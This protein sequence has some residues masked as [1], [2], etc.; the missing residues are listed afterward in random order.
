MTTPKHAEQYRS[1]LLEDTLP[2]WVEHA[3]DEE[4]GG[5]LTSLDRAGAVHDSDKWI[6]LQGRFSWLLATVAAGLPEHVEAPRWRRLARHGVEFLLRHGFNPDG[7]M[8]FQVTREGLHLRTRR[9]P[10]SEAFTA[11]AFARCGALDGDLGL[12][13]RAVELFAGLE[14]RSQRFAPKSDQE[15]R[16]TRGLALPMI[17]LHVG[18]ELAAC[19][20]AERFEEAGVDLEGELESA[21]AAIRGQWSEEHGVLLETSAPEGG[22]AAGFEGRTL[23][24][25]HAIEATWFLLHEAE[26]R[27]EVGHTGAEELRE[28]ALRALDASWERGWDREYGGLLYF[29][30]LEGKPPT[31]YLHDMKFWWPHN[32]AVIATLYAARSAP[33]DPRWKRRHEEVHDWA[34]AHFPDAEHGEWFGYLARDGRVTSE[35]KGTAWKGP[36]HLPRMQWIG[37]RLAAEATR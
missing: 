17:R 22:P 29:V 37:W 10:F 26:R 8:R 24:P 5:F 31:E 11:L 23:N 36:Y 30:D 7:T 25:G 15:T 12:E 34:H 27:A 32:E 14:A 16:P 19:L 4:H 13:R 18:H 28:F 20:P 6:W 2:F 3:V 21:V 1:G 33:E 35:A 9:Y